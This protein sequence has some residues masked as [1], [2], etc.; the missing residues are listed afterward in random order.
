MNEN[1]EFHISQQWKSASA[2]EKKRERKDRKNPWKW[3]KSFTLSRVRARAG[4]KE[5]AARAGDDYLSFPW[6]L[7][8]I[9]DITVPSFIYWHADGAAGSH[10]TIIW[11]LLV[12]HLYWDNEKR[13]PIKRYFS[14]LLG[15]GLFYTVLFFAPRKIF[16][17]FEFWNKK[18]VNSYRRFSYS[19]DLFSFTSRASNKFWRKVERPL[20]LRDDSL[21][22]HHTIKR[23]VRHRSQGSGDNLLKDSSSYILLLLLLAGGAQPTRVFIAY[24]I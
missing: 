5:S 6:I 20:P 23:V 24:I 9:R 7:S 4:D 14:R 17:L 2:A 15:L 12:A 22:A 11:G 21:S 13:F 16:A 19:E 10:A 1:I 8:H 3:A 18:V